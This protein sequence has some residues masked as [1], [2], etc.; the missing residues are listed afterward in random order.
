MTF[1]NT[2]WLDQGSAEYAGSGHTIGQGGS[3]P[4]DHVLGKVSRYS[5]AT[6]LKARSAHYG[7]NWPQAETKFF[8]PD[9]S[10]Q[11]NSTLCHSA[12]PKRAI[13]TCVPAV[14]PSSAPQSPFDSA[15][16]TRNRR[17][18]TTSSTS[19]STHFLRSASACAR[20]RPSGSTSIISS[21]LTIPATGF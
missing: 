5:I 21:R 17:P 18:H 6:V 16:E 7:R 3:R 10:A 20:A 15:R 2:D 4:L 19:T 9:A 13:R 14:T 11:Q 12:M 1:T 8:P